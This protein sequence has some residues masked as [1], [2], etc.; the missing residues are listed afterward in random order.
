ML[1]TDK[2]NQELGAEGWGHDGEGVGHWLRLTLS[3][4]KTE[5]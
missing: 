2:A 1:R 3:T 5:K 4:G